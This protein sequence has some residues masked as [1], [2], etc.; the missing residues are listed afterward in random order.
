MEESGQVALLLR[1]VGWIPGKSAPLEASMEEARLNL[2]LNRARLALEPVGD[3]DT[4]L[5]GVAGGQDVGALDGLVEVAED[6]VDQNDALGGILG[7][8]DVWF[9]QL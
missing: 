9:C 6:V 5:L 8:S 4:V 7:T 1:S 3:E 2:P